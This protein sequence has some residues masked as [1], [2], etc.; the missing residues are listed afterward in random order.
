MCGQEELM[1]L[2]VQHVKGFEAAVLMCA[3]FWPWP[4]KIVSDG[5]LGT[6]LGQL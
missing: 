5:F 1:K 2:S 6:N 4:A 3:K